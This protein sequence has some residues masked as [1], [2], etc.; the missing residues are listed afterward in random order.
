[1]RPIT[2]ITDEIYRIV[3]GHDL[4]PMYKIIWDKFKKRNLFALTNAQLE[5]IIPE[6]K[7]AYEKNNSR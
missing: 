4:V 7:K 6:I 2:K 5:E 3:Y 1:M